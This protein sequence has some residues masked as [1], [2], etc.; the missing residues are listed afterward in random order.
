M[1]T[2]KYARESKIL[3][4]GICLGFQLAVVE[5]ARNVLGAIPGE[6]D[7]DAKG[8]YARDIVDAYGRHDAAW[9]ESKARALYGGAGR[10]WERHRHQY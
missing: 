8:L 1:L 7:V 3:F 6:F 4:W 5:W 2:I 9:A 10:I